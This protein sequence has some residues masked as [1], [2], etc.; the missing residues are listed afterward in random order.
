MCL[1]VLI[2]SV[3]AELVGVEGGIEDQAAA[4]VLHQ[5]HVGTGRG[6]RRPGIGKSAILQHRQVGDP[7]QLVPHCGSPN[8]CCKRSVTDQNAIGSWLGYG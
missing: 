4:L 8:N 1:L 5:Q 6:S 7:I 2:V 3:V